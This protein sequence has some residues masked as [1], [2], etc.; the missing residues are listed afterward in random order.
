MCRHQGYAV[1]SNLGIEQLVQKQLFPPSSFN[2]CLTHIHFNE[3]LN[4]CSFFIP[5]FLYSE[6]VFKSNCSLLNRKKKFLHSLKTELIERIGTGPF[7]YH[8]LLISLGMLD[9]VSLKNNNFKGML[10]S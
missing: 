4:R 9:Q 8:T 1:P 10:Y 3:Y 5:Q 2:C 6:S 7:L